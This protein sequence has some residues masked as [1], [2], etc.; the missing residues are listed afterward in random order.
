MVFDLTTRFFFSLSK[1]LGNVWKIQLLT[2]KFGK[3]GACNMFSKNFCWA[4]WWPKTGFDYHPKNFDGWMMIKKLQ[5]LAIK[6]GKK[7][8]CV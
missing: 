7:E 5:L 6:F 8:K 1:F 3:D 2:I 4:P